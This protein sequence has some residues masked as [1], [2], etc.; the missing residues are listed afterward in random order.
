MANFDS[1]VFDFDGTVADT[2]EGVFEGIRYA[3][4]MEGLEQPDDI[5]IRKFIGPPLIDSFQKLYPG[6][7]D[8]CVTRLLIHYRA[9]YSVEGIYKFRLYDGMENL[10]QALKDNGVKTG[11]ASSKPEIFISHILKTCDLEKYFDVA[12]GA[13]NNESVNSTKE[14][15]VRDARH[16]L[17][18]DEKVLM[19]GDRKFDILGAHGAGIPCA[20]VLFGYGNKAE[21]EEFHAD[22]IVENCEELK[23]IILE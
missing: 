21:F 1:V 3:I 10:L 16:R 2:G 7:D 9:K 22:Y 18:D 19:I 13:N 20:A 17:G 11:I 23:K 14:A 15:L 8:D 12:V 4:R 5:E 6:I